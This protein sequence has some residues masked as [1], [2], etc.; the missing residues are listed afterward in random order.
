MLGRSAFR[1]AALERGW[2]WYKLARRLLG[3]R[4]IDRVGHEGREYIQGNVSQEN[5]VERHRVSY[6]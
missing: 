6:V 1:V 2:E 4:Q 3:S 5:Q